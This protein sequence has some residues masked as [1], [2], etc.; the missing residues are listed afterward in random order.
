MACPRYRLTHRSMTDP[1]DTVSTDQKTDATKPPMTVWKAALLGLLTN[2]VGIILMNLVLLALFVLA[3]WFLSV[4]VRTGPGELNISLPDFS[5]TSWLSG[6]GLFGGAAF[7]YLAGVV[8]TRRAHRVSY[9][10]GLMLASIC[11]AMWLQPLY[12]QHSVG[13]NL[14][15]VALTFTAVMLGIHFGQRKSKA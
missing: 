4:P 3:F 13:K 12:D 14:L 1:F 15:S 9:P 10:A 7:S 8:C 5:P 6:I 2:M 11:A